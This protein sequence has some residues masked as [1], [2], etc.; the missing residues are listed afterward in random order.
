MKY[1]SHGAE[2]A[3]E[4]TDILRELARTAEALNDRAVALRSWQRVLALVPD[5]GAARRGVAR[6]GGVS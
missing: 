2:V 4:Y 6:L 3:P 5:D 1:Y